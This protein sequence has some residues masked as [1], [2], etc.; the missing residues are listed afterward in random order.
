VVPPSAFL[1][2]FHIDLKIPCGNRGNATMTG[3]IEALGALTG[4]SAKLMIG[5]GVAAVS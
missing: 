1:A 2:E 5:V 3:G 4:E